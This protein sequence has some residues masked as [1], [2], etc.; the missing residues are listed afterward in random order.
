MNRPGSRFH[1]RL[2]SRRWD[3]VRR[4]V[5]DRDG[6]RCTK[7]GRYASE[8]HHVRPLH[9]GGAAWEPDNLASRCRSCHI[10]EHRRRR[11]LNP[12]A[13]AW[14]RLVEGMVD[15]FVGDAVR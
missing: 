4:A 5:L 10:E 3:R 12:E 9:A 14:K 8:V 2:P 7:C 13:L 11:K 15:G 6:W 1:R